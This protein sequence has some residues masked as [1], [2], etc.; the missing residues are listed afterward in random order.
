VWG[1]IFLIKYLSSVGSFFHRAISKVW[2]SA[3]RGLVGP[4]LSWP[5]TI[6]RFKRAV[7]LRDLMERSVIQILVV[8]C[9]SVVSWR[10]K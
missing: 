2:K 10:N 9:F 7:D 5:K 1:S 4:V 6:N 8:L 3:G